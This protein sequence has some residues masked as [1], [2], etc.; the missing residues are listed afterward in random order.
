MS[1]RV[2]VCDACGRRSDACKC[3]IE[4]RKHGETLHVCDKC[5]DMAKELVDKARKKGGDAE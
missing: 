2:I 4:F 5:I 1:V 3:I